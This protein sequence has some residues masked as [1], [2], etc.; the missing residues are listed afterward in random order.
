MTVR[1]CYNQT[2]LFPVASHWPVVASEMKYWIPL[3]RQYRQLF[4]FLS[5]WSGQHYR[6]SKYLDSDG[7]TPRL[8]L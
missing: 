5:F 6:M 7:I 4:C 3:V 1:S 2:G 8:L